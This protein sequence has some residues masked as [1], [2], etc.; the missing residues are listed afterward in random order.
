[1]NNTE[2]YLDMMNQWLILI[3]NGIRLESYFKNRNISNIAV[4]G[5]GIYGRHFIREMMSSDVCNVL[6]G[7]DRKKINDFKGVPIIQPDV[8]IDSRVEI[9][10]N[11]VIYDKVLGKNLERNFGIKVVSLDDIIFEMS[12]ALT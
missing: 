5:M 1:M 11:T 7:L 2:N 10:V 9:I 8:A 4:Y 6:C 3:H 12:G